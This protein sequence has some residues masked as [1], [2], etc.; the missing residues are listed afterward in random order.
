MADLSDEAPRPSL[1]RMAADLRPHRRL[2]VLGSLAALV[3]AAGSSA[4]PWLIGLVIDRGVIGGNMGWVWAGSLGLL[5]A[6]SAQLLALWAQVRWLGRFAHDYLADL[7]RELLRQ[8]FTM[9]VDFYAR[10]PTGRLVSRLTSDVDNM[11]QF[12]EG[13]L[14]LV[15]RIVLML[16]IITVIMLRES[17]LMTAVVAGVLVPLGV[18]SVW[19]RR[20][21]Y[22]AQVDVRD[23]MA[24]MLGHVSESLTGARIIQAY[25]HEDFR[26]ETFRRVNDDTYEA[27][28]GT[29]RLNA[30]FYSVVEFVAP[31]SIAVVL[32]TGAWLAGRGT[33]TVGTVIAFTLYLGKLF[34]PIQQLAELAQVM[35][36]ASASYAKVFQFRDLVPGVADRA[37]AGVF[38]VGPGHVSVRD[39]TF[40]Y[41]ADTAEV[42]H[43][44][45]LDIAPGSRVAL[46]GSS[47]AGKTTLGK[48]IARF[49]DV[50]GGS[51]EVDGQDVRSV[52][53]ASLR[54]HVAL[55]PQQGFLFDGTVLDN[56]AVV[57]PDLERDDVIAACDA[58]GIMARIDAL[59]DGL[60]TEITNGG[61]SLSSGQRQLIALARALVAEP[62][63]IVLDEATSNLD[64]ATDA[65]VERALASLL[66][67]RTAIVI[68]HRVE[69]AM[70][71]D[72]VVLM[73]DGRVAEDGS[74]SEL[75]AAGGV[76][77]G[78]V[79]TVRDV[80]ATP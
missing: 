12:V 67:G 66:D 52:T 7:R 43:G 72:R 39:V 15:S 47:G 4:G 36:Q 10:V 63:V 62:T 56:I 65:L 69:T 76:F 57:R 68:A 49:H 45:S 80:A 48:L 35:Q 8:L 32:G 9:D 14:A 16:V 53:G 58:L 61:Q 41:D 22:R 3:V 20:V 25:T 17:V 11:Q 30:T 40:R 55:V 21:A 59:P 38:E 73:A 19:F 70:R 1:G 74:P 50:S 79:D 64:P 78:W 42:L 33:V 28:L 71:A 77:A 6:S 34:E 18:A 54:R 24:D 13:G 2:L 60:A 44:V 29:V 31:A 23:R 46:V 26:R 51:I 75:R 5:V 27:K 37:D